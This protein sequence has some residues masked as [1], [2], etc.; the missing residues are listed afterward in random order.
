MFQNVSL[1]ISA[2]IFSILEKKNPYPVFILKVLKLSAVDIDTLRF[3]G[4]N[5]RASREMS[6]SLGMFFM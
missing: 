6:E 4:F 2:M 5:E 3:S 1:N